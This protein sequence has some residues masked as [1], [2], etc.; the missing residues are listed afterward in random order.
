M[1]GGWSEEYSFHTAPLLRSS[2]RFVMGGDC[3]T[4][5]DVR[6]SVTHAMSKFNPDFVLFSGDMVED[7]QK[8]EQW[9]NFLQHMDNYWISRDNQK[10]PII[11]SLGN[12][13]ENSSTF[14]NF[15]ALPESCRKMLQRYQEAEDKSTVKWVPEKDAKKE[16]EDLML[17][18]VLKNRFLAAKQ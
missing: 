7:G 8:I 15:F 3:R 17:V 1:G 16:A 10:I 14:Y 6:D 18:D 5:H 13:E 9:Y 4:T 12:H 11:P 2:I